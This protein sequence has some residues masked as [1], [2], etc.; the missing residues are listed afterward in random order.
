MSDVAFAGIYTHVTRP[1]KYLDGTESRPPVIL[2]CVV[3]MDH[4][5][6]SEAWFK[7]S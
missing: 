7:Q 3:M 4:P 5:F 2:S 1:N 6:E